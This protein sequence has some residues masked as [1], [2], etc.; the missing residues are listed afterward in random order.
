VQNGIIRHPYLDTLH[1]IVNEEFR[2]LICEECQTALS[3]DHVVRHLEENHITPS[4]DRNQF[5]RAITD[6]KLAN[7]L[8]V[9]IV[10]PRH[11]VHGLPLHDAIACDHCPKVYISEKKMQ[12][13]HARSHKDVTKPRVWRSCRAQCIHP[14]RSGSHRVL[15]EVITAVEEGRPSK[16]SLVECLLQ[17]IRDELCIPQTVSDERLVTPWLKTTRWH[18][19]VSSSFWDVES[20]RRMVAIPKDDDELMPGLRSAVGRYFQEGLDLL[21]STDELVLQRLNSPDPIKW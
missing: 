1:L 20:L 10:G 11:Q 18:E 8:P 17:E 3:K 7:S 13:H 5:T 2:F 15:W 4:V 19:Y 6:I 14:Q 9:A 16:E 12:V 21:E